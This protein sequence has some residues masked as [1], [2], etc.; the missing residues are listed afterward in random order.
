MHYVGRLENLLFILLDKEPEPTN[1]VRMNQLT[2]N[3][4]KM[5]QLIQALNGGDAE[6]AARIARELARNQSP[7]QFSLDMINE[8]GNAAPRQPPVPVVEPLR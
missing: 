8:S 7:I 3:N 1:D 4:V 2:T 5:N 6:N